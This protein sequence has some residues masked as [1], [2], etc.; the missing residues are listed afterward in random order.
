MK[1]AFDSSLIKS[2][3]IPQS[4]VDLQDGWCY[5]AYKLTSVIVHDNNPRYTMYENK[6][7]LGK[8]SIENEDYDSLVFC[9]HD[10]QNNVKLPNFVKI[11][12]PNAFQYCKLQSLEFPADSKLQMIKDGAFYGSLIESFSFVNKIK[13]ICKETFLLSKITFC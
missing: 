8:S 3:T 2:I 1:K 7:I 5:N 11:I 13:K 10:I 4:L 6:F 12:E 9:F